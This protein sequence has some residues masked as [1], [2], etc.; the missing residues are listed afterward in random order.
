VKSFIYFHVFTID[1]VLMI[2]QVC[3]NDY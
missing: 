2:I 1:I 3:T